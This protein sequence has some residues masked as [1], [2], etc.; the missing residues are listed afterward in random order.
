MTDT[1]IRNSIGRPDQH[2]TARPGAKSVLVSIPRENHRAIREA[3][4][5]NHA[6][7]DG[8]G[9]GAETET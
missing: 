8:T 5:A 9:T 7:L 2:F 1:R 6:R 4:A 3:A